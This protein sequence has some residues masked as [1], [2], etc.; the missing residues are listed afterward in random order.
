MLR[1]KG[2]NKEVRQPDSAAMDNR[3]ISYSKI[4]GSF[5]ANLMPKSQKKAK[6][7]NEWQCQLDIKLAGPY[8]KTR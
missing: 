1:I 2:V 4:K 5:R 3:N 8:A 7:K 6:Y